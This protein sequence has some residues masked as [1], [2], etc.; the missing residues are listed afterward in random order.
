MR[1]GLKLL[2]IALAVLLAGEAI[3][4]FALREPSVASAMSRRANR[5]YYERISEY[6]GG[7]IDEVGGQDAYDDLKRRFAGGDATLAHGVAHAFGEQLFKKEGMQSLN[8]CDDG[9]TFGCYH[10]FVGASVAARGL[11]ALDEISRTCV[12]L[13]GGSDTGCRHGMGHGIMELAGVQHLEAALI[14]CEAVQELGLLGCTHGAFMEYMA[15]ERHAMDK[16]MPDEPCASVPERFRPSCYFQLSTWWHGAFSGD[17]ER[18][19]TRCAA[20]TNVHERD[21]CLMS[22]G[23]T[24]AELHAYD[25]DFV[26]GAC[27]S[28]PS[29]EAAFSCRAGAYWLYGD[30]DRIEGKDRLCAFSDA[31]E[32]ERCATVAATIYDPATWR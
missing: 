11:G 7:R 29:A 23:R 19:G 26:L 5:F 14:D 18:M 17:Y 1:K 12:S 4:F 30:I 24:A 21:S 9:V 16:G 22:I 25:T 13:F 10:G 27:A 8:V 20:L 32:R 15:P 3:A 2:F 31:A 28:M 6:W